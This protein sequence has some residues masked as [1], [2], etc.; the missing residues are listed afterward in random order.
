MM[1]K[2][3]HARW[4]NFRWGTFTTSGTTRSAYDLGTIGTARVLENCVSIIG[5]ARLQS[6]AMLRLA[7]ILAVTSLAF[8]DTTAGARGNRLPSRPRAATCQ[9]ASTQLPRGGRVLGIRGGETESSVHHIGTVAEFDALL[10]DSANNLV[11]VDFSAEWCG[12]CRM[13]APVFEEMATSLASAGAVFCKIDVD[14]TP[15]LAD[16]FEVQGMPTFL[17]V[18]NGTVVDRFSGASIPKLKETVEMLM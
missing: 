14:K 11:V 13:I 8:A 1:T 6:D 7:V 18:K 9:T 5:A 3:K 17:F 4:G 16:R 15:E 2:F 10:A 12:P